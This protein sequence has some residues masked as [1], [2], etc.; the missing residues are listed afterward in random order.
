M[1]VSEDQYG[2]GDFDFAIIDRHIHDEHHWTLI[3]KY[4]WLKDLTIVDM[5]KVCIKRFDVYT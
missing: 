1:W 4:L 5:G 3:Q 2:L